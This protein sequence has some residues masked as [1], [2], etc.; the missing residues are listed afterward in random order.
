MA[1]EMT[2]VG[3]G[4]FLFRGPANVGVYVSQGEAILIDS[5]GDDSAGRKILRSLEAAELKVAAIVNTHSHADHIGGNAFVQKRT[6][7]RVA[8]SAFEA[9]FIENPALEP[10]YLWSA[11]APLGLRNKFLQAKPS[12]VTDIVSFEEPLFERLEVLDLSGHMPGMIGIKTPDDVLFL[13]DSVLSPEILFKYPIPFCADV[14]MAL[15]T[16]KRMESLEATLFVPSHGDPTHDVWP[17][18]EANRKALLSV[19]SDLLEFCSKAPLTRDEL[20]SRLSEKRGI[21][22]DLVE[23]ALIH[24]T[25]SAFITYLNGRGFLEESF[26]SC[27][28]AW[29]A[30]EKELDEEE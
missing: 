27:R 28:V 5:G 8:A 18:I 4:T 19:A 30:T 9:P 29:R 7:C 6:S 23:F 11:N 22:L 25:V 24:A 21:Q 3:E 1:S 14:S 10:F 12:H 20:I 2:P 26:D 15:S 13:S 16:L 17:L